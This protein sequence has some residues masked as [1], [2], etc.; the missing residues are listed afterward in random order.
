MQ[1]AGAEG[2][3]AAPVG[4]HPVTLTLPPPE[5]QRQA[6]ARQD[7]HSISVSP[8]PPP[9]RQ[10]LPSAPSVCRVSGAAPDRRLLLQGHQWVERAPEDAGPWRGHWPTQWG[11]ELLLRVTPTPRQLPQPL[12]LLSSLSRHQQV[13]GR[14]PPQSLRG[15]HSREG[16]PCHSRPHHIHCLGPR[17]PQPTTGHRWAPGDST[18]LLLPASP[19]RCLLGPAALRVRPL[20]PKSQMRVGPQGPRPPARTWYRAPARGAR[21]HLRLLDPSSAPHGTAKAGPETSMART[22]RPSRRAQR[23]RGH[24]SCTQSS[25]VS[26]DG[27]ASLLQGLAPPHWSAPCPTLPQP[28]S[29]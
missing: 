7:S 29:S 22:G 20:E 21:A 14:P 23:K 19:H 13:P 9:P 24:A 15:H 28:L 16:G 8:A 5:T 12:L 18:T 27:P 17:S 26:Q 10:A 25:G 11:R 6:P 1:R 4:C 3:A 2:Q